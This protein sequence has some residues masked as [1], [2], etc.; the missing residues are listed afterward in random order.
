MINSFG[1][2]GTADFFNG[3]KSKDAR[4]VPSEIHPVAHRKLDLVNAA[5]KLEDLKAPP[6]NML[7][8]LKGDLDGYHSIR[9]NAQWRIVFKWA[10]GA[11]EV[12][13]KDYH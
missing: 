10:N 2:N 6:G 8:A 9:I 11:Y 13:I 7:E 12:S 5:I 4:K 1:D 3:V